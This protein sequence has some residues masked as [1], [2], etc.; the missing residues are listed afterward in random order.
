M[1][2]NEKRVNKSVEFLHD[3]FNHKPEEEYVTREELKEA[4]MTMLQFIKE[5]A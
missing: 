3:F 4:L 1:K 2:I 5:D